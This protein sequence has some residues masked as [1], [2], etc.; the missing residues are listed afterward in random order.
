MN[1]ISV[2][3]RPRERLMR[4][5]P[6]SL[7][8]SE[9][10]SIILGSGGP[11]MNAL[12]L[13]QKLLS[14]FGGLKEL[15]YVDLN[16]LRKVKHLGDAKACSIK[17]VGELSR[18]RFFLHEVQKPKMN[19]P[20]IVYSLVRPYIVGKKV[21]CLYLLCLDLHQRLL[22]L[23]LISMGTLDQSLA[24]TREILREALLNDSVG[25]VLVHNH[26]SGVL[27]PSDSDICFTKRFNEACLNIGLVFVD[28]LIVAEESYFSFKSSGLLSLKNERG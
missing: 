26:P 8:D 3:E 16:K 19:T 5:G 14:D 2:T 18:R 11:Q 15:L 21:E 28:H 9:L 24:D 25:I 20:E 1:E 12:S 27:R 22:K 4:L 17:A 6:E 7:A 10:L 23:S 13:S